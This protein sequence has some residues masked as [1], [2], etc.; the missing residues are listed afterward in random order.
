MGCDLG[1]WLG[2]AGELGACPEWYP[3]L[4]AARWLGVA[5]WELL[6]RPRVWLDWALTAE[7]A[8]G[9][10][11]KMALELAQFGKKL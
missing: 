8:E 6:D 5:P 3:V 11:E 7:S 4:R 10:G 9:A 2:T 1:R